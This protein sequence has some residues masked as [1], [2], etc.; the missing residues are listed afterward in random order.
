M[1]ANFYNKVAK[2][3]GDYGSTGSHYIS[4]YPDENPEE[5][6]K[7]KLIALSGKDKTALD[8]GCADGRFTLTIAAYFNKIIAIDMS[9]GMLSAAVKLQ[10]KLNVTNV[11]F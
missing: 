8:I 7:E 4:E 5:V 6:F 9:D 2:K 1:N 10:R 3:F 11:V